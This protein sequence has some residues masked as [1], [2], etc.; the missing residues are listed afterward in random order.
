[1]V[2]VIVFVH[3]CVLPHFLEKYRHVGTLDLKELST[4]IITSNNR[5]S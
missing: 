4:E 2:T 5:F 3:V 1:M